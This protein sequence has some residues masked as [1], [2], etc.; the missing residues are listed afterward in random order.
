MDIQSVNV[1]PSHVH[2]LIPVPLPALSSIFIGASL[3]QR[4][5]NKHKRLRTR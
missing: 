2:R 4:G 1:I 5:N 3:T